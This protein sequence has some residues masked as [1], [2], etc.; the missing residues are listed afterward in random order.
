M[1]KNLDFIL[2]GAGQG[3]VAT[4]LLNCG[5]NT[6]MLRPWL[7][8]DGKSYVTLVE[9]GVAKAY[10]ITN[11]TATLRKDDWIH[12]D[13]AI[14]KAARPRLKLVADLRGAG[15][16]YSIPNGMGTTVLQTERMTDVGPAIVSMDGLRD[17][18]RDRPEFDL[19]NLPLP[20]ISKDFSFS[21]RQLATS[22]SGGSPLDTTMAEQCGR[23]VAEIAEEMAIGSYATYQYGGGFVYG[24]INFPDRETYEITAP[25]TT[26]W[27]PD[28]LV[29]EILGM[30]KKLEDAY[31]FG[32]YRLYF[33]K[34][35]GQYLDRD[36]SAVKGDNTLRDRVAKIESISGLQTL[37]Y[38]TGWQIVMVQ[39]TSDVIREVIGMDF[40]TVQW[41]SKGGLELNFK[42][43]GII[44]PQ[45]R[46]DI[47]GKSGV[48]HGNV[49]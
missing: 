26:G 13:T 20:I 12:L 44:V 24:L 4:R 9:N 19:T 22:R 18:Q 41:P 1:H 28:D 46:C 30:R 16:T 29:N 37:D 35:W 33:A 47:T 2:N 38:L 3:D 5:F 36:Y 25:T 34:D 42:V 17:S 40:T 15:L 23:K 6:N 31:H 11:T 10:P 21:A 48:C 14:I 8:N 49:V 7:G 27:T 45:V 39:M 43:M 32:P